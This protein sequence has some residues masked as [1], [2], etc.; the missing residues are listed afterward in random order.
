MGRKQQSGRA[1]GAETAVLRSGERRRRREEALTLVELIAALAIMA[2]ATGIVVPSIEGGWRTR[3]IWRDTRHLAATIR[4]L[5]REAVASG[6]IQELVLSADRDV[7][8]ASAFDQ[9]VQLSSSAAILS[10][11]GGHAAGGGIVRVLFFPNGGTSGV[12]VV[13]GSPDDLQ[14]ARYRITLD[15]LI[16]TVA[17]ADAGA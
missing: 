2:I 5:R 4:H 8:Q 16:G 10:V 7:Y 17:V 11:D 6:Q 13:I 14:G 12:D 9:S 1:T 3:E 15:P